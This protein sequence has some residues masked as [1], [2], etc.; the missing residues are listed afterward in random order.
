MNAVVDLAANGLK[1]NGSF[2]L[3]GILNMKLAI[4]PPCLLARA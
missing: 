4:G 2:K 1:K 3:L